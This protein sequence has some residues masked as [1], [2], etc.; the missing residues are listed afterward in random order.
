MAQ[1]VQSATIDLTDQPRAGTPLFAKLRLIAAL[2]ATVTLLPYAWG[3]TLLVYL[4]AGRA[5]PYYAGMVALGIVVVIVLTIGLARKFPSARVRRNIG[6]FVAALWVAVVGGVVFFNTGTLIPRPIVLLAFLPA[7]A[8]VVWTGWM[9]FAPLRW[10]T[11]LGVL[12]LSLA[13]VVPFVTFFQVQ[14]LTGDSKV[15]FSYRH[16]ASVAGGNPW[17][18]DAAA[19]ATIRLESSGPNQFPGFQGAERTAVIDGVKL[20]RDW[21]TQPPKL[22]WKK[23]VGEG[24]SGFAVAG[25]G[26][27]TL[28]QR[29]DKECVVAR[30]LLTGEE[31]WVHADEARFDNTMGGPGPRATPAIA[32][33]HVYAIG[34]TGILNCLNG[35]TGTCVWQV[36]VLEDNGAENQGHGVCGSPLIVDNLV[37]I[38]PTG[39][40]GRSLAAYDRKDGRR[41]WIA[42]I[43]RASYSS[44]MLADVAGTR[45]ILYYNSESVA[46]H[47]P[48]SGE[49][50]WSYP[51]TNDQKVVCSQ[52]IVVPGDH[53]RVLL[54]TGYGSGSTLIGIHRSADD[55]WQSPEQIWK[56]RHMKT[57]FTTAVAHDNHVYGLD[58][59]ILQCIE[60]ETGEAKW[61]RGRYGHGQLLL[62]DDLLLIQTEPGEAVLVEANPQKLVE[63]GRIPALDSKTW[64]CPALAGR[65]LVTRND[66]EAVCYELPLAE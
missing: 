36:N 20:A 28:E 33:G 7:T 47:D 57:K 55:R 64:N 51:W 14:G 12:A 52:P 61:K 50:L 39:S 53:N 21:N 16:A 37:V 18:D 65:Y 8:W 59:G 43:E 11:R 32:D 58:D 19:T 46:A 9:F 23:T 6:R 42:G 29:D 15:N 22:L 30:D 56:S 35:E 10:S 24:W 49:L 4:M 66:H 62:V 38:C 44:P 41:V 40:D 27:V 2:A 48:R 34:A 26:A 45:Q 1:E 17:Q 63:L 5:E 60:L 54:T 31:A 25:Q 3:R 13:A